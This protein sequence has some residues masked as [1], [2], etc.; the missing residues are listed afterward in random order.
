M[1]HAGRW[2]TDAHGR[3]V[4]VHGIDMVY[5]VAPYPAATGFGNDDA[6]FLARMGFN[7]VRVGVIWK[8]VEPEPGVYD[9]AYVNHAGTDRTLARHGIV[10]LL[11]P[12]RTTGCHR[13][14]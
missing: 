13:F 14:R 1:G 4:I 2:I 9:D 6:A 11:G 8:A 5:K 12:Y 10:S 7:A 3:V